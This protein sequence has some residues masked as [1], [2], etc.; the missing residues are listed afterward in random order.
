MADGCGTR[1]MRVGA[2]ASGGAGLARCCHR[3]TAE[4]NPDRGIHARTKIGDQTS[5]LS[6]LAKEYRKGQIDSIVDMNS[7]DNF[8]ELTENGKSESDIQLFT[9]KEIDN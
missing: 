1:R 9:S 5:R 8:S 7:M 2:R 3:V 4:R 6:L